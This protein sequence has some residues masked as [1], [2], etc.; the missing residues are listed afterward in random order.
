MQAK[1]SSSSFR[2]LV[3]FLTI[4]RAILHISTRMVYPF[5]LAF[6]RGMGV[7]LQDISHA[8]AVRA[9]TGALS[10][11]LSPLSDRYGRKFGL[12]MGL[13]LFT[14]GAGALVFWPSFT[15]FFISQS[16]CYLGGY[17]FVSTVHAYLG[18][19][20]PYQQRGRVIAINEMSWS[21]SFIVGV[22]LMGLLIARFGWAAPYPLLMGLGIAATMAALWLLPASRGAAS[23]NGVSIWS[24]LRSILLSRSAVTGLMMG[25]VFAMGNEVVVLIYGVWMELTFGLK[26]AAL[27]AVSVVFGLADLG[28]EMLTAWLVD[29]LGKER[30]IAMGLVCNAALV[31]ILPWLAGLGVG[32]A[33]VGLFFFF[34][35]YE[36]TMVSSLPLMSEILPHE[37]ATMMGINIAAVSLGRALGALIAPLIFAISFRASTLATVAFNLLALLA[38][39]RIRLQH[40]TSPEPAASLDG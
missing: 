33:I 22:P 15:T 28:G 27:G 40:P 17:L 30:S 19:L 34:M 6:T 25:L 36:I 31:A 29:R 32:G 26:I 13:V 23:P 12:V 18:D 16:L 24:H 35:T 2:L 38:L 4:V 11:V 9:S 37:R 5:M 10:P 3:L 20:V 21:L 1:S 39:S 14:L 7:E 8:I